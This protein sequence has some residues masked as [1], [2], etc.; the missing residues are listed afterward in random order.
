M[1]TR[2]LKRVKEGNNY[3]NEDGVVLVLSLIILVIM[4][5][6]A[7]FAVSIS[8]IELQSS[9]NNEKFQTSFLLAEGVAVESVGLLNKQTYNNLI[10]HTPD[11]YAGRYENWLD[12]HGTYFVGGTGPDLT[13]PANWDLT[14][15][16]TSPTALKQNMDQGG[17]QPPGFNSTHD[18]LLFAAQD[19][20]IAPG[21]DETAEIQV[22]AYFL[23]SMYNV[24][25]PSA[26]PGKHII[27]MGYRMPLSE[28]E[29]L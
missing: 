19:T 13:D 24:K 21:F 17:L 9:T 16:Y 8:N 23:Y 10:Q 20:G 15:D 1:N 29:S 27:E 7:V 2:W 28:P 22:R 25:R 6:L 18:R 14:S 3:R 26:F 5:L 11:L 12:K 4:S